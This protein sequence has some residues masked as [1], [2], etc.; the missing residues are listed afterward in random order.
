MTERLAV[1]DEDCAGWNFPVLHFGAWLV[2]LR[3]VNSLS[4]WNI[5]KPCNCASLMN[6]S[7]AA[8]A[9]GSTANVRFA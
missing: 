9:V 7:S 8:M 5:S 3:A 1:W 2:A 4:A 6:F